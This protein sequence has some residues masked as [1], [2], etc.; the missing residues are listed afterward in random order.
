M[1]TLSA[2]L[3]AA[4]KTLAY[5]PIYKVTLTRSGQTTRGYDKNR[6]LGITYLQTPSNFSAEIT[7][8]NADG[9]LTALDFEH[10]EVIVS[11]G[12]ATGVSRSAWAT[13]TAYSLDDIRIPIPISVNGFQYRCTVAGTSHA[14]NEPTWPTDLG[15]RVVDEGV[16]WEMD[17]DDGDEYSRES[18]LRVRVQELHSGR[19]ILR[20][21]L[22]CEGIPNQMAEDKAESELTLTED[23]A[24]TA[25]T[26]ITAIVDAT[27][28]PYSNY[29]SF[30]A[31]YDSTDNIIDSFKP[32]DYFQ[33]SENDNRLDKKNE[34]LA[35]TGV[36]DRPENDG[37]LHF[38]DPKSAAPYDYE[39]KFNVS[40]DHTFWNK[41]I[42]LR[43]V[44]PNK[45]VVKSGETHD[46]QYS[47]SALSQDSFDLA[48][49]THTTR[50]RLASDAEAGRIASAIIERYELDDER[51][52]VTVPMNVGQELWDYI[53][54]TDSRL[55]SDREGSIQYLQRTVKIP[56]G[57]EPFIF[58]MTLSFGKVTSQ[59]LLANALTA[60]IGA[61][62]A[63]GREAEG[64]LT[65]DQIFEMIDFVTA[66]MEAGR[67]KLN[68][69]I[70][71]LNAHHDFFHSKIAVFREQLTIPGE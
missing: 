68:E 53:K 15:V 41:T 21:I 34:L 49:K 38:F 36:K 51:G 5:T 57:S 65:N 67:E 6:V 60:G 7:L 46:N 54:V 58:N 1:R 16:T 52:F 44:H 40:G 27:L 42:R 18:P 12:A 8:H 50:R 22:R 55:G 61:G 25:K 10:Y 24:R 33:V 11:Y 37:K 66:N 3:E 14:T 23:D 2:T 29:T 31:T 71:H 45:E 35:H 17:G 19:G 13:G 28:S 43:F 9:D 47:G 56:R 62:E 48:P 20:V 59:S 63:G 32:K 70:D 39:Y 69:V 26:L 64:R 30:T 4:M